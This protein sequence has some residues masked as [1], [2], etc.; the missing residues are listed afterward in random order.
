M[1]FQGV[2]GQVGGLI[3]ILAIAISA[4]SQD[5][6]PFFSHDGARD[7]FTRD[8]NRTASAEY[9]L[10][11]ISQVSE[12]PKAGLSDSAIDEAASKLIDAASSP[13][14]R[15]GNKE[16]SLADRLQ[17]EFG[18]PSE[19]YFMG[20]QKDSPAPFRAMM[21]ALKEGDKELA[22]RYAVQYAKYQRDV[23]EIRKKMVSLIGQS[24]VKIGELPPESWASN[25]AYQEDW[26]LR[27]LDLGDEDSLEERS[28]SRP[29]KI[30]SEAQKLLARA[31]ESKF[32]LFDKDKKVK[33][34]SESLQLEEEDERAAARSRLTNR[35]PR[36]GAGKINIYFF[37]DPMD[38]IA[39]GIA[40]DIDKLS[41]LAEKDESLNFIGFT[42]GRYNN[43][44]V[45]EYKWKSG[46]K[47][48]I[49]GGEELAESLKLKV[50]PSVVFHIE[51]NGLSHV[52]E[53]PR[54]FYYLDEAIQIMR[55]K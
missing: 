1:Y 28:S 40:P 24:K 4:H 12:E 35:L 55:G 39:R 30:D 31:Q 29:L 9:E 51:D 34:D 36:A 11:P 13:N 14:S 32:S 49:I 37:M 43:V 22:F 33:I 54:S 10:L 45:Q 19:D 47:F 44:N 2:K 6:K 3:A 7:I 53:G 23:R 15:D 20:A 26:Y 25:P 5:V 38:P 21:V 16:M 48:P 50:S 18:D 41:K 46:A 52:E 27:E 42:L 8:I 17:E